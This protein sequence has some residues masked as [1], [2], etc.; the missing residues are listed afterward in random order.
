MAGGGDDGV[1]AGRLDIGD[2]LAIDPGIGDEGRQVVAR[3]CAS[4]DPALDRAEICGK[5]GDNGM[6]RAARIL[7]GFCGWPMARAVSGSWAPNNSWV[8]RSMRAARPI[9]ARF[10]DLHD[11]MERIAQRQIGDEITAA[12]ALPDH[13]R[14]H[15]GPGD[16]ADPAPSSFF[17]QIDR[18]E[19]GLGQRPV[20]RMIG[21]IHLH[22]ASGPGCEAAAGDG[23]RCA[24]ASAARSVSV[25]ARSPLWNTTSSAG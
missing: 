7:L 6:Q 23:T 2:R 5:I 4:A 9:R 24:R 13:A 21:G 8:R 14:S 25:V 3:G 10:Q 16:L 15:G 17:F 20:F 1:V 19:P 22:A 12:T 18:H 11:D